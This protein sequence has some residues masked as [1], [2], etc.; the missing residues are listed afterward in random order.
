MTALLFAFAAFLSP[1]VCTKSANLYKQIQNLHEEAAPRAG[2]AREFMDAWTLGDRPFD[3]T[4]KTTR[5]FDT[6]FL[7]ITFT[8]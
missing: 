8:A 5:I 7:T 4:R 1:K 6:N 3:Q 2:F